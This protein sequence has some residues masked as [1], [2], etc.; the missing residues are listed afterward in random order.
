MPLQA[1]TA[2]ASNPSTCAPATGAIAG[3][4]LARGSC[5]AALTFPGGSAFAVKASE[6]IL[7]L[8]IPGAGHLHHPVRSPR[9]RMGGDP[10]KSMTA[11]Q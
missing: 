10:G 6:A 2:V 9:Q 1:T 11:N 7:P 5:A 4:S 8:E 3:V